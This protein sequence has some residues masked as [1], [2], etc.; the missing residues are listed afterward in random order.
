[1][2]RR[3]PRMRSRPPFSSQ[4]RFKLST[5]LAVFG[6]VTSR[7]P[8]LPY[9]NLLVR[10]TNTTPIPKKKGKKRKKEDRPAHE[11]GL[12]EAALA[13]LVCDDRHRGVEAEHQAWSG[14]RFGPN[15]DRKP[16]FGHNTGSQ[17]SISEQCSMVPEWSTSHG[18]CKGGMGRR[19]GG[20]CDG[21][22]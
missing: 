3:G 2:R 7:N 22:K 21:P 4:A 19:N 6:A 14:T 15:T 5:A 1:M 16:R 8:R 9:Y 18:V 12:H 10:G 20:M 17:A 11:L 13:V